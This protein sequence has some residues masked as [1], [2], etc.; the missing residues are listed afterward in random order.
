MPQAVAPKNALSF[1]A[2]WLYWGAA[3]VP[4]P[5]NG[6][7]VSGDKFTDVP[8]PANWFL[9]GVTREGHEMT[10]DLSVDGVEAAEYLPPI[11]NVTTGRAVTVGCDMMQIHR[12]NFMR[13][14]NG[15]TVAT[16]GVSGSG[17]LLTSYKL[18]TLGQEV[19][20]QLLW[21]AT[22]STERWIAG[23]VFQTG[24]V[25]I[26]RSKGAD[27]ASLPVTFTLEP[28]ANGD[29]F[30]QYFAGPTRGLVA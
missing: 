29:E 8:N 27:N 22:D 6:G 12:A 15:G 14:F 1:G 4:W 13:A 10:V 26:S 11:L 5:T 23:S 19:R 30:V 9:I 28:D 18:P 3:G 17:T 2:G 25:S 21:E 7:T 16:S 20:G 24:S